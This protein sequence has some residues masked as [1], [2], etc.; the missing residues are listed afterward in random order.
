LPFY[1]QLLYWILALEVADLHVRGD[2]GIVFVSSRAIRRWRRAM[3]E[4]RQHHGNMLIESR[5]QF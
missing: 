5:Q 2:Y 1:F 3:I 4:L